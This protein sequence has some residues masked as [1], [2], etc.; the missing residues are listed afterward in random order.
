MSSLEQ[1]QKPALKERLKALLEEYGK[2]A[3]AVYFSIFLLVIAGFAIAIRLGIQIEGSTE[4]TGGLG[5]AATLGAAWVAAKVTQPLRI[6]ATLLLTPIIGK[7]AQ[8][9][10]KPQPPAVSG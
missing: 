2:I 6:L 9:M 5:L 1:T 10:R 3:I 7:I 8:R 4:P